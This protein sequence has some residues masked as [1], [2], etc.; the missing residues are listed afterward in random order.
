MEIW[1]PT[2]RYVPDQ[3]RVLLSPHTPPGLYT[4]AAGLWVQAEGW[5]LP[6]FNDSGVQIG[7]YEPLFT[8]EVK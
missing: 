7:D 3:H 8:V 6:L 4:V 5:R 1:W 2:D